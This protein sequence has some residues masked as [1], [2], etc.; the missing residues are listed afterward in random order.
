[1]SH[2]RHERTHCRG[3]GAASRPQRNVV[4]CQSEIL[5]NVGFGRSRMV[6]GTAAAA[7]AAATAK[8]VVHYHPEHT[9]NDPKRRFKGWPGIQTS[10]SDTN[11]GIEYRKINCRGCSTIATILCC[12]GRRQDCDTGGKCSNK[13]GKFGRGSRTSS[14]RE[15]RRNPRNLSFVGERRNKRWKRKQGSV[16]SFPNL[17]NITIGRD[18]E[19]DRGHEWNRESIHNGSNSHDF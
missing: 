4:W 3:F 2:P 10:R 19:R 9:H 1:M 5:S 11:T 15:R 12:C 17:G 6:V 16:V 13:T 14:K 8:V 7:A 18:H